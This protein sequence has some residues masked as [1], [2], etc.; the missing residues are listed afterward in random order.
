MIPQRH[1]KTVQDLFDITSSLGRDTVSGVN[2]LC[3]HPTPQYPDVMTSELNIDTRLSVV[4][5]RNTG[6]VD[7]NQYH[8]AGY[9]V[10]SAWG[11]GSVWGRKSCTN[12]TS[13]S[14]MV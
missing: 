7:K 4:E 5:Y 14:T 9:V 6:A 13:R 2:M 3:I 12:D 11:I 10:C 1:N 8:V